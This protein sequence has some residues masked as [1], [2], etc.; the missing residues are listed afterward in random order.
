MS[1]AGDGHLIPAAP[2]P[3]FTRFFSRYVE[4]MLRRSFAAVHVATDSASAAQACAVADTPL[5][6][7]QNHVSWWDPL[8]ACP[9]GM[10]YFPERSVRAPM[11]AS[12]LEKFK[13]MRK[14]GI[15]G[16]DPDD[17]ASLQAMSDYILE[18][19]AGEA[20]PTLWIT[21]Q[22]RFADVRTPIRVRPGAAAIA[23]RTQESRGDVRVLSLAVEYAFW[24]DKKPEIFLRFERCDCDGHTTTD[25][26]RAITDGMARN[27][28]ALATLVTARDAAP[29]TP[30]VSQSGRINPVYDLLL[31][32]RGKSGTL[33]T[34][35]LQAQETTT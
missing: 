20:R 26:H 23:A 13:F 34:P 31:K 25:W 22:G 1:R 35:R 21:P 7:T 2:A 32:L 30:L 18:F 5:I 4:R 12:Q 10:T 14:L 11:D 28:A 3:R 29:F 27:A 16:I 8:I 19:F 15:F 33:D 17:P 6:I 24:L 9:A